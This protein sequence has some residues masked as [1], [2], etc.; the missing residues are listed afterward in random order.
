MATARYFLPDHPTYKDVYSRNDLRGMLLSGDLSRSD[1]VLDDET[2][3]AH[4]LGD[5]LAIPYPEAT[6]MP[7]RSTSGL[8]PR[9]PLSHEF[10]ANTP[11]PRPENELKP[12]ALPPARSKDE[13]EDEDGDEDDQDD[14][15][16]NDDDDDDDYYDEEEE[17]EK[18]APL[19]PRGAMPRPAPFAQ[20]ALADVQDLEDDLA[21]PP[22]LHNPL[23]IE[24]RGITTPVHA[25]LPASAVS[26]PLTE[27]ERIPEEEL[28]QGHPSWFAFPRSLL[29][30][31]LALAGA[32]CSLEYDFGIEWIL[33]CVSIAGLV[34]LFVGLD[35][36][37]TTY[38]ITTR[39]VEME[40]GI[41]GR[42]TKE[43][44][45]RD[46]RAIDVTQEGYT[47]LVGLGTVKFD[48]SATAG[49]EVCFTNV[50]RPHDLKELVRELQG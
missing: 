2:G 48:S 12:R 49:P 21:D 1:M 26:E 47:A 25:L 39:R 19:P 20:D 37:T 13:Q 3:L 24:G 38:Y 30:A 7:A 44:R 50:R 33:L 5:L 43:V 10:R 35:R 8:Q 36:Y 11:L 32:Y 4:L 41:V 14:F 16:G 40:Y 6:V 17:D 22:S 46:I 18:E 31:I 27:Y 34:L 29:A 23:K 42:N 28:Y 15:D 45:I 9:P